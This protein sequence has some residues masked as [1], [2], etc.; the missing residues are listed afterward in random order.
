MFFLIA[1]SLIVSIALASTVHGQQIALMLGV[2]GL[3]ITYIFVKILLM[4]KPERFI[5]TFS[6][7]IGVS[8]LIDLVSVPVVFPLL[9]EN[10][11]QNSVI[12]FGL[13]ASALYIWLVVTYGFI[14]SRAI[15][16]TMGYGI[17]IAV[18]YVLVSYMLVELILA[19]R[20]AS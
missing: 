6:S 8:I 14:I 15:S 17:S 19:G 4:N 2:I 13:L 7:I 10:T 1:I 16:S 18:A 9:N 12:L 5:Q 20:V 3:F 11:N